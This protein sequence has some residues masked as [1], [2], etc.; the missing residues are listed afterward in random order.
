MGLVLVLTVGEWARSKDISKREDFCLLVT[1][2]TSREISCIG[3]LMIQKHVHLNRLSHTHKNS[4]PK[5]SID[6]IFSLTLFR[7]DLQWAC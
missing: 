7:S 2:Y 6:M 3:L 1:Y 4:E 5:I